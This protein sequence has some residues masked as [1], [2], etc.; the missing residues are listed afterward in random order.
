MIGP[1]YF[2]FYTQEISKLLSQD[3]DYLSYLPCDTEG[4]GNLIEN[5]CSPKEN[6]NASDASLYTNAIGAQISDF[7]KERLK[8]LVRQSLIVFAQEVDE[9]CVIL[10]LFTSPF[11]F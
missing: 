2:G 4:K 9:V 7:K 6:R 8:S 10:Y 1:D 3:E 5:H 11:L